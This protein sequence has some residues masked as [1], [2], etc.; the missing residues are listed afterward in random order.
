MTNNLIK[1]LTI[2][3]QIRLYL[4]DATDIIN[5]NILEDIKADTVKQ[6]YKQLVTNC[7]LMRGLLSEEDQRLSISIRLHPDRYTAHCYI[8]GN[9]NI[10][11]LL[12][13]ELCNYSGDIANLMGKGATLSIT[14]GSWLGGMFTGT[15]EINSPSV[16]HF[17]SYFFLKSDQLETVF[18]SWIDHDILRGCMVQPLPFADTNKLTD[19]LQR[20]DNH[21]SHNNKRN[22]DVIIKIDFP[23]TKIVDEYSLQLECNCSREMFYGLLMSIDTE[24][25]K[26]SIKM[27][28]EE[29]LI[30]GICGKK[31]LFDQ[32]T[33]ETIIKIKEK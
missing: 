29:E 30:C 17:F 19:M 12:S 20:I 32:F 1:L 9:G 28:Q 33:L 10:N 22:W 7:S 16:D 25:L 26:Q 14:R 2:D 27:K 18:Y 31:Y 13:P 15:V 21:I 23:N 24:E 11:C 6:F 3:K 8:D 5:L 4:V